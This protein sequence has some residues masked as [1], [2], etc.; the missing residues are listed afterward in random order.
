MPLRIPNGTE[1][2]D[3][4]HPSAGSESVSDTLG[5]KKR[6]FPA[7]VIIAGCQDRRK[8][9][10]MKAQMSMKALWMAALFS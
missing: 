8:R 7:A 10:Q 2:D 6:P 9:Q 1:A 3:K 4:N 5:F